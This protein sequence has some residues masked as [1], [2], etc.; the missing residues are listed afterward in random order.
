MP[1]GFYLNIPFRAYKEDPAINNS[2]L[3]LIE[4]A[5]AKFLYWRE[6]ERPTTPT[7]LK[8][9]A[10]HCLTLKPKDFSRDYGKEAAPRKGSKGRKNWELD[11]PEAEALSPGVWDEAHYMADSLQKTDCTTARDLLEAEEGSAE[12]SIWFIDPETGLSCKIRPDFLR[13][14]D[15]VVDLKSTTNGSPYGFYWE[16]KKYGYAHQQVFY[17]RG[18]NTAFR[19]AGVDRKVR[20]FLFVCV[21]S[22]PPYLVSVH[23]A[24]DDLVWQAQE[25]IDVRLATYKECLEN[26]EWPGYP[27]QILVS[28]Q[29]ESYAD[30]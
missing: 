17:N 4:Q 7:F 25:R 15:I 13:N 24:P 26:D 10:L 1:P 16:I 29:R 6:N 22:V 2:G 9:S 18:I 5:P 30:Y 28:G 12:M 3:K 8:G 20:E 14:D 23:K 19:E 27:D 21:E 11:N